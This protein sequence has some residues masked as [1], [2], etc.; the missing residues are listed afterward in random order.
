MAVLPVTGD[1]LRS[2]LFYVV[3]GAVL[4]VLVTKRQHD[5]LP[6][7]VS[8]QVGHNSEIFALALLMCPIVQ[9]GVP[10]L[11]ARPVPLVATLLVAAPLALLAAAIFWL[12][13]PGTVRTLNEPVVAAAV[14]TVYVVLRRPVRLAWLLPLPAVALI[15]LFYDLAFVQAQAESLVVLVLAPLGFDVFDRTILDRRRTGGAAVRYCWYAFLLVW[16]ALMLWANDAQT[17]TGVISQAIDYQ[18]RGAEGFWGLLVTEAYFT[19]WLRGTRGRRNSD[20]LVET[21]VI[22]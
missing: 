17:G 13:T 8:S 20:G 15:V 14:L 18:A 9:F 10:R 3:T 1:A 6:P 22:K 11:R 21:H 7:G 16:P 12:P 2:V 5:F 4:L 19:T